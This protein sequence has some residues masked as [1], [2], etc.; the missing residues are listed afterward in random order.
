MFFL[1]FSYNSGLLVVFARVLNVLLLVFML[2]NACFERPTASDAREITSWWR[3]TSCSAAR[4]LGRLESIATIR[5]ASA[6][7]NCKPDNQMVAT[8]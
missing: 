8:A 6:W 5:A 1:A 7:T 4:Q 2:C 3:P